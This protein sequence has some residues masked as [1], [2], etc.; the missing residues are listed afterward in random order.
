MT[1]VLFSV[2]LP[3]GARQTAGEKRE[4]AIAEN[5]KNANKSHIRLFSFGV[6]FDVNARLLDRLST[7]NSG[8]SEYVKPNQDI[9]ASVAKFY[10]RMTAPVMTDIHLALANIDVNRL[11][12]QILPDLFAGGQILALRPYP[13]SG[14]ATIHL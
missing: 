1:G 14:G 11:Y 10:G 4:A 6:G 5:V 3:A 8:T 7:E 9:E 2:L 13:N 12:P